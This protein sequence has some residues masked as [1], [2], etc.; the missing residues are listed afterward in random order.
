MKRIL[1][2]MALA[3][4]GFMAMDTSANACP[5]CFPICRPVRFEERVVT[6]Y[7]PETITKVRDV[8]RVVV[9][10]VPE[11]IVKKVKET[12][13]VPFWRDEVRTKTVMVPFTVLEKHQRT[14]TVTDWFTVPVGPVAVNV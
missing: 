5:I 11:T 9:R 6:R 8:S 10:C 13:M 1:L 14:V 2:T 7:R 3:V 12:V 4:T